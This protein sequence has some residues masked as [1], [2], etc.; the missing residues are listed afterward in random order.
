MLAR[1]PMPSGE[2]TSHGMPIIVLKGLL[3]NRAGSRLDSRL[4]LFSASR[5]GE[6]IVQTCSDEG[7]LWAAQECPA[8]STSEGRV[9]SGRRGTMSSLPLDLHGRARPILPHVTA[10]EMDVLQ[11][12]AEGW[13]DDEIA[14]ALFISVWTVRVHESHLRE[15]FG[16]H[17]RRRLVRLAEQIGLLSPE[18][19][20]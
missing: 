10:R 1:P 2:T 18:T 16:V 4:P 20:K 13:T 7:L 9:P 19:K 15:K 5:L 6:D 11:G 14:T 3:G 17:S 12:V 8:A